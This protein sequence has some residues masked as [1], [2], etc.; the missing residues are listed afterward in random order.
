MQEAPTDQDDTEQQEKVYGADGNLD[1]EP[2]QAPADHH[3]DTDPDQ[4]LHRFSAHEHRRTPE[5][6]RPIGK[7]V[8]LVAGK[9]D[10]LTRVCLH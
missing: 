10:G 1:T 7:A 4:Q 2:E 9:P 3:R 6:Q 5:K 8:P